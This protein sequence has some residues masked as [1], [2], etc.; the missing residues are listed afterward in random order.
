CADGVRPAL[1]RALGDMVLATDLE[2]AR[3]L[4]AAHPE[5]RAVTSEGDVVG[6]WAAAGG[7]TK[8][9]SYIEVQA[10]VDEARQR[11]T[12]ATTRLEELRARLDG[13]RAELAAREDEVATAAET[14]RQADGQRN[15]A[16]RRLAELGAAAKSVRAE[17]DRLAP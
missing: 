9:Q 16:A 12:D 17:A 7:S 6:A 2:H 5:L 1:E 14:R 11:R 3:N 15:S 13:A 10:A 4:V 8:A